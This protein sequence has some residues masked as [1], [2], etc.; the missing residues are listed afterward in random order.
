MN[1][2][3]VA[4]EASKGI[5]LEQRRLL[6]R[7]RRGTKELDVLLER[8][9]RQHY[10]SAPAVHRRAFEALLTLSDPELTDYLFGYVAPSPE[11]ADI[12]A[13]VALGETPRALPGPLDAAHSC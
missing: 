4:A 5:P 8:F 9:A 11:L 10:V 2:G 7:C 12:V 3:T 6:W 1:G 13:W